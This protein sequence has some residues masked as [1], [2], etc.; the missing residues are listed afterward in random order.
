MIK[1]SEGIPETL[2]IM[3][4][5][6]KDKV[7]IAVGHY[8]NKAKFFN[9]LQKAHIVDMLIQHFSFWTQKSK[10]NSNIDNSF[11]RNVTVFNYF[12]HNNKSSFPIVFLHF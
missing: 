1:A 3:I 10:K 7:K 11:S 6:I 4:L 8:K 2:K 12:F 5:Y 9:N